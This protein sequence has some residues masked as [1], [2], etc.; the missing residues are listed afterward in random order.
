MS[1]ENITHLAQLQTNYHF[2]NALKFIPLYIICFLN[3]S[4]Q[5]DK[6]CF[7]QNLLREVIA[8]VDT[9]VIVRIVTVLALLVPPQPGLLHL[10]GLGGGAAEVHDGLR[11]LLDVLLH[12]G[13]H[14]GRAPPHHHGGGGQPLRGRGQVGGADV[15]PL[16][17]PPAQV[18]PAAGGGGQV[19][20]AG[21]RGQ[22]GAA[23]SEPLAGHEAGL[24][25]Q[26]G[27]RGP[28]PGVVPPPARGG[29]RGRP[30]AGGQGARGQ[31]G[32]P[33]GGGAG[34][35]GGG[36][37]AAGR[38]LDPLPHIPHPASGPRVSKLP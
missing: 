27:G 21:G 20:G 13:L 3:L 33:G 17:R 1:D 22:R 34:R 14:L 31:G 4:S 28:R 12:L 26:R 10:A 16:L 36:L 30:P 38:L 7:V 25:L 2:V 6:L 15:E 11:H 23:A 37:G 8:A 35:G 9:T 5:M 29:Q 18:H 24:P 19:G 32:G